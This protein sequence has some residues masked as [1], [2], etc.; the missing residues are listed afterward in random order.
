MTKAQIAA[1]ENFWPRYGIDFQDEKMDFSNQFIQQG[2]LIF[3]IGFGMGSSLVQQAMNEPDKNF[4]GVEVHKPGVG[5]CLIQIENNQ[6]Q[7]LKVMNVDANRVLES[8]IIPKTVSRLQLYFPDP[9]HKKKHNKRRIVT[10]KFVTT[11]HSCLVDGGIFHMATDWEPY[12][13]SMLEVMQDAK[14]F[15]NLSLQ[16]DFVE[17]PEFRPITKFEIRGQK[18]GHAVWDLMFRKKEPVT[19]KRH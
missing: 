4:I 2:P 8:M 17:R 7:N 12:A 3:E 13:Q 9:W 10:D 19:L 16:G 18:L 11:I 5:A 15:E 6:L 1:I 14:G